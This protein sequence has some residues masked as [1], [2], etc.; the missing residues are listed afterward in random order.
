MIVNV[1]LKRQ[2]PA[3]ATFVGLGAALLLPLLTNS[4]VTRVLGQ[5]PSRT[6]VIAGLVI[7]WMTFAL[8][9]I[10]V[11]RWEREPLQSIGWRAPRWSTLP[12]GIVV[13]VTIAVVSAVL[14]QLLG[15]KPD[16]H[17]LAFLQSLPFV[18]RVALVITAGVFE[19]TLYRG[20][21]I[22]R[23][24]KYFW[25]KWVAAALTLTLFT[26]AHAPAFG[27]GQLASIMIVSGFVTLLYLWRR[28]LLLNMVT[29]ATIDAIGLLVIPAFA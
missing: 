8:L 24:S 18:E 13:G 1:D 27:T 19:E 10:I 21:A 15:L 25:G 17:Y 16:T 22:E 28:D 11:V 7:H 26:L 14:S 9:L 29:H 6:L 3:A 2:R 20:Y 5:T 12:F 23:L 4:V